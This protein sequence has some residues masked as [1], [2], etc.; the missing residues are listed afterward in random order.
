M[1]ASPFAA[2]ADHDT[3]ADWF[4]RITDGFA[5]AAGTVAGV[6]GSE[7]GDAGPLPTPFVAVTVTVY[8]VPFVSPVIVQDRL[9]VLQDAPPG[10]T[11]TV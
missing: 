11:V 1:I 9:D 10:D 3:A 6:A 7:A 5:G 4:P 8:A 2:G